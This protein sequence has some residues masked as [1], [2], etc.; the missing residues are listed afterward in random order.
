MFFNFTDLTTMECNCF[1]CMQEV[2]L[3]ESRNKICAMLAGG[4]FATGWWCA[5]GRGLSSYSV[6]RAPSS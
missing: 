5:I 6:V 2:E 3:S 1:T 4:L